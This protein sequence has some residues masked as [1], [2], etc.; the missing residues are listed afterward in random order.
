MYAGLLLYA[1]TFK[2]I[3]VIEYF[4]VVL[5]DSHIEERYVNTRPKRI[6]MIGLN[7]SQTTKTVHERI[8]KEDDTFTLNASNAINEYCDYL[9]SLPTNEGNYFRDSNTKMS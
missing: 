9:M 8:Y 2:L 1:T 3:A 7:D 4:L 6:T 5:I